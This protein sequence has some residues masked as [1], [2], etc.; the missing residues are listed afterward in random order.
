MP[1]KIFN[2]LLDEKI[3]TFIRSFCNT[4]KQTFVDSNGKLIHPGEFGNYRETC[5]K[6]F[7]QYFIPRRLDIEEGFIINTSDE[8]STECDIIIYDKNNTP[9]I[10]SK[11]MQKFYPVETVA[12]V[13]EV[14]SSLTKTKLKEA[15]DKL[16]AVKAMRK[17]E[18]TSEILNKESN[19]GYDPIKNPK[20][21]LFTF[22]ICEKFD[23]N[24]SN[25]PVTI[26]NIYSRETNPNYQ[27]NLILSIKDGL[28]AYYHEKDGDIHLSVPYPI[29]Y[30]KPVKAV[31]TEPSDNNDHIKA[32]ANFMFMGVSGTTLIKPDITGYLM[33]KCLKANYDV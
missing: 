28:A 31:I 17:G 11:E 30:Q 33:S 25:L 6:E 18:I 1:N 24:L 12:A 21:S 27:H 19:D 13:G 10:Q 9:L 3:D 22:L 5:C 7:L 26:N 29:F 16:S 4:A 2:Y 14:K 20:D 15:L 8:V 23:F 32:F